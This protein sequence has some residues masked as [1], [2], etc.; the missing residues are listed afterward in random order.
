MSTPRRFARRSAVLAIAAASAVPAVA[1]AQTSPRLAQF[2]S[3]NAL[4]LNTTAKA[5]PLVRATGY[6]GYPI[7]SC[8]LVVSGLT[9]F[10]YNRMPGGAPSRPNRHADASAPARRAVRF[11]AAH[12][13]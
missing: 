10:A 9:D 4:K 12:A 6:A 2:P 3:C 8:D 7:A 1:T 11:G 13:V 5:V